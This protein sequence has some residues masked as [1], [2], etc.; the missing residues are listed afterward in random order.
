MNGRRLVG[1]AAEEAAASI[2]IENGYTLVARNV[3]TRLGEI[4]IIA[5]ERNALAIIEVRS[6][7]GAS[8]GIAAESVGPMKQR[9]LVK[10]AGAYVQSLKNP[11]DLWRVDVLAMALDAHGTLLGYELIRNAVEG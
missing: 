9:R 5:R 1:L 7:R 4:D 2:L 8:V 6:R 3:R 11:P 10:L